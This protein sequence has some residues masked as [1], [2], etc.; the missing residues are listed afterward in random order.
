MQ[1]INTLAYEIVVS[2]AVTLNRNIFGCGDDKYNLF[3]YCRVRVIDK[4]EHLTSAL[5]TGNSTLLDS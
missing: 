5:V 4:N 2:L 1:Q 3:S